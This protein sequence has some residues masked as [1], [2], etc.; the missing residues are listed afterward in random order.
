MNTPKLARM[1]LRHNIFH[2]LTGLTPSQFIILLAELRP[3]WEAAELKRKSRKQRKRAIGAGPKPKLDLAGDLFLILLFYRT[4]AGQAFLGLVVGLDDSNV[5]RRIRRLEPILQ[6]VFRIPERKIE[7]TEEEIWE[8]I[9]DATEQETQRRR[10]TR[11]SGKQNQQTIKTQIHV[12]D[13]GVIK[14]VSK[15]VTGNI[16][17]K[18]LYD[19]SRTFC[20]SP[21]GQVVRIKKKGDLGYLGTECDI[22]IKKP[23]SHPLMMHETYHNRQHATGRIVV[24]HEIAHLKQFG[25]L[26]Q[27]FRHRP[28][29][30]NLIFRNIAGLR[31][32]IRTSVA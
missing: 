21:D 2:T 26:G 27:R 22:P 32:L 8:L 25:A 16:H 1:A 24:E 20:R 14:A 15:S 13:R 5:S 10:G 28:G 7:I 6:R 18:K 3:H 12:T 31:N 4:Y 30:H 19:Q 11:F 9:V 29:R 23:K 17:D